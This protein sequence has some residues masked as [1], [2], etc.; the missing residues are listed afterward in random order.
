[1]CSTSTWHCE[2]TES[3]WNVFGENSTLWICLEIV[4]KVVWEL[5]VLLVYLKS[6]CDVFG[7]HCLETVCDVLGE[8]C[9]ETVCDVY[10]EHFAL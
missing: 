1:M 9:L 8:L 5:L 3:V 2:Y 10:G 7:E 4:S 6:V